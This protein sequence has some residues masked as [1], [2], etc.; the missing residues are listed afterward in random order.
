MNDQLESWFNT[1]NYHFHLYF[2]SFKVLDSIGDVYGI[3]GS[4]H[5][6]IFKLLT[7]ES[8]RPVVLNHWDMD[9]L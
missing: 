9:T 1:K 8:S 2:L 3:K 4:R 5:D 7:F 6:L